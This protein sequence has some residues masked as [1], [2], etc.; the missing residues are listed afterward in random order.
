MN[1]ESNYF[2]NQEDLWEMVRL[3]RQGALVTAHMSGVLPEFE[4]VELANLRDV[5]DLACGPGEWIMEVTRLHPHV[6][7]VGVDK[8]KRMI[9]WASVQAEAI[10]RGVSF[11]VMDI[12]QP[13]SF[14]DGAFDLVNMRFIH[15]FMKK[16]QWAGLLD[17]CFRI[18]RPGGV[19]RM[20][21]QESG[22]SNNQI[23]QQYMDLWGDAWIKSGHSFA[24]SH[25]YI[26]VTVV[27]KNFLTAAGFTDARHRPISIDLSTGQPGHR[28][29]LE[30]LIAALEQGASFL[31]RVGAA[32]TQE[33]I[34]NL[35]REMK[36]L[37]DKK[38]FCAF[39]LLQTVW[40]RKPLLEERE[41]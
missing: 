31:L 4:D 32:S 30:N 21:E 6:R 34:D 5:A 28:E 33:E 24:H 13:L 8:S 12:T 11:Q 27:L 16:E 41:G 20:T 2:A 26:G 10:E 7:A 9:E 18:L 19:L 15:S 14:P 25:A 23:Y 36:T 1:N 22:F 29:L 35:H 17:E 38:E 3:K 39:W 37:L 40:A